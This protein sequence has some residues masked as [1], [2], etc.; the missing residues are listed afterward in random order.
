VV[1][2]PEYNLTISKVHFGKLTLKMYS[3]GERVLRIEAIAHNTR[4]LHCGLMIDKFPL[5]I[6]KLSGIL[7]RFLE[8]LRCIDVTWISD[9]LLEEATG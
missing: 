6:E 1:E 3:K 4:E 2:R 5:M 9:D 7:E 8:S